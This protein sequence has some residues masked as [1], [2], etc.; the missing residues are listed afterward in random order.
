MR[1][2]AIICEYNPFHQGHK[3]HIEETRRLA[4]AECIIAIMSGCFVQRGE[5]AIQDEQSRAQ[6]AIA[7]GADLVVELPYVYACSGAE[8]F[9]SG[10]CRIASLLGADVLS[11]GSE[12]TDISTMTR[13]AKVLV[14]EPQEYRS[15]LREALEEGMSYARSR[16]QA[17]EYVMGTGAADMLTQPNCILGIE[18]IKAILRDKANGYVT[19]EPMA[20][21]RIGASHGSREDSRYSATAARRQMDSSLK[22][23]DSL[24]SFSQAIISALRRM[25]PES[26]ALYGDMEPGLENRIKAASEDSVSLLQLVSRVANKR[27]TEARVRRILCN[28]LTGET[29]EMRTVAATK[30]PYLRVLAVS[31][32]GRRFLRQY[33]GEVPTFTRIKDV[34]RFCRSQD[35]PMFNIERMAKE[36]YRLASRS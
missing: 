32:T 31:E 3:Y 8:L 18:Y 23:V 30:G 10:G 6:Q 25:S 24:D 17:L 11:F 36:Q 4:E 22:A 21:L 2:A 16:Q 19:P 13:I 15:R 7:G 27:I 35:S 12:S 1:S 9:A 28:I 29:R 5:P 14:E 20:V 34:D 26:I 33:R